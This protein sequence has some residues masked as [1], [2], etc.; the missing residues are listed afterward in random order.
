MADILQNHT[1]Q[2]NNVGI[3]P[4]HSVSP[5]C[6]MGIFHLPNKVGGTPGPTFKN[7]RSGEK[8]PLFY[9]CRYIL[10]SRESSQEPARRFPEVMK[11]IVGKLGVAGAAH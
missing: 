2:I 8:C 10:F 4:D 3:R 11:K 6:I 1:P 9:F 5:R 7:L